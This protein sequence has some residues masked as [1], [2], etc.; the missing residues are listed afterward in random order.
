MA[1]PFL[2]E[3]QVKYCRT[4]TVRKLIPLAQ[5][6]AAEERCVSADHVHCKAF[7]M[8]PNG[9]SA[10]AADG[11]C[12]YLSESLMQYCGA[13]AVTRFVPFSEASLSRCGAQS[14]RYCEL[15]SAM[16]HPVL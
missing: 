11:P 9:A 6:A 16:A 10:A 5:G 4:A 7:H 15:Y 14:F 12:P 3:V 13:A 1:C 2:Q 8:E